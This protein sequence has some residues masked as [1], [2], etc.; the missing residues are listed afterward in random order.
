VKEKVMMET[1]DLKQAFA[2]ADSLTART[3]REH[4]VRNTGFSKHPSYIAVPRYELGFEGYRHDAGYAA[5][6]RWVTQRP[7]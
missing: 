3:K 4:V 5:L 6:G 7:S 1:T 2:W